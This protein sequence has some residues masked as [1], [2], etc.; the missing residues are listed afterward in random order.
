M[1]AVRHIAD[2]SQ[3]R[4]CE[5]NPASERPESRRGKLRSDMEATML[6]L[7]ISAQMPYGVVCV[8]TGMPL[9]PER[10][11]GPEAIHMSELS[12]MVRSAG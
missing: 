7:L 2:I 4:V 8:T 3:D 10:M 5:R 11:S 1:A 12:A 6:M 9:V